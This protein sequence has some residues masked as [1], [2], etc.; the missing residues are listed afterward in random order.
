MIRAGRVYS[1]IT[2]ADEKTIAYPNGRVRSTGRPPTRIATSSICES[3]AAARPT[4]KLERPGETPQSTTAV[5]PFSRASRSSVSGSS[6]EKEMSAIGFPA[7]M[8]ARSIWKPSR[9]GSAPTTASA[10]ATIR[11]ISEA[12][13]RSARSFRREGRGPR[14][15]SASPLASAT[16]TSKSDSLARSRAIAAPT[17]PQ[18]RT[19]ML[20]TRRAWRASRRR[21]SESRRSL[22]R[23]ALRSDGVGACRGAFPRRGS[24]SAEKT[25]EIR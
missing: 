11:A 22:R 19:I 3:R 7:P 16:V 12:S 13:E 6:G 10:L 14:R 18:P 21:W 17:R 4:A 1:S 5:T 8:T 2:S 25:G 24:R 20:F 9:P 23:N 15:S